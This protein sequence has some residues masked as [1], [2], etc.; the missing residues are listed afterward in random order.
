MLAGTLSAKPKAVATRVAVTARSVTA[1]LQLARAQ[2]M[3]SNAETLFRIDV[4]KGRFGLPSSMHA[5]PRGMMAAVMVAETER[6]RRSRRYQ[7]LSGRPVFRRR[8][9]ADAGWAVGAH[10]RQL[11]DRR[12]AVDPMMGAR[13]RRV[14][15]Q[16]RA[17]SAALRCSKSSL[18][19]SSWRWG[20][21][22]YRPAWW[23]RCV[24]MRARRSIAPRCGLRSRVWKPQALSEALAPGTRE[25]LIADK[26]RWRQTVTRT[27]SRQRHAPPQGAPGRRLQM[28]P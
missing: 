2:A 4:E 20:S 12:T 1:T 17:A 15:C 13:S 25:G 14:L 28:A 7:I 24:P 8:D 5:L 21:A 11:A 19:S 9:R 22:R 26:F 18:P 27:S 16:A 10:R 23:L 3:S 6:S